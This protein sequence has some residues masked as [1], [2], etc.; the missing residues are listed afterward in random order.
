MTNI[1][2]TECCGVH[3]IDNLEGEGNAERSMRIVCEDYF[4]EDNHCAF[5]TFTDVMEYKNGTAFAK[6]IKDHK[7]GRVVKSHTRRNPNSGNRIS[8]W[9]WEPHFTN[10]RNW[11]KHHK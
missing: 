4:G 6:Y 8:I 3:E 9:I 5:Y 2:E 11:W 1:Q 10:L 7:L